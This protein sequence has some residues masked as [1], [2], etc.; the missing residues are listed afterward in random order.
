MLAITFIGG[1]IFAAAVFVRLYPALRE[2]IAKEVRAECAAEDYE[3]IEGLDYRDL[4]LGKPAG[5]LAYDDEG[6]QIRVEIVECVPTKADCPDC[7]ECDCFAGLTSK[8][9]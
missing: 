1:A 4:P 9:A 3:E 8:P 6:N 7:P 2:Q 5:L